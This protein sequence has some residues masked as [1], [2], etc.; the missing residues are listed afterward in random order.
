MERFGDKGLK[1]KGKVPIVLFL[2][3]VTIRPWPE[4]YISSQIPVQFFLQQT[5]L[6]QQHNRS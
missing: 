5:Q 4:E 2:K 3:L 1:I 6:Y